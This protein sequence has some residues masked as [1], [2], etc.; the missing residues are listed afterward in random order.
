MSESVYMVGAIELTHDMSVRKMTY[1][2]RVLV[3][4]LFDDFFLQQSNIG[5]IWIYFEL[6]GIGSRTT[7]QS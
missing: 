7:M 4:E 2:V 6:V 1:D 5:L 3:R